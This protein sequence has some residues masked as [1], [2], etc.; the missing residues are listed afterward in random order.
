MDSQCLSARRASPLS[1][2]PPCAH[3]SASVFI[4]G[5]PPRSPRRSLVIRRRRRRLRFLSRPLVRSSLRR[6]IHSSSSFFPS[7]PSLPPF[8]RSRRSSFPSAAIPPLS[9]SLSSSFSCRLQEV[10]VRFVRV[11][12]AA[13][14]QNRE[15]IPSYPFPRHGT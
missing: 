9:P 8:L 2:P 7:L 12:I 6:R 13:G 10:S 5:P 14:R 1:P 4:P 3:L 11:Q 15:Q